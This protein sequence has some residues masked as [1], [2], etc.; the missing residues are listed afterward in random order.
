MPASE[1]ATPSRRFLFPEL[2]A[3]GMRDKYI[4][5]PANAPR[6]STGLL[7]PVAPGPIKT[8]QVNPPDL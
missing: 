7:L 6:H 2:L 4:V 3:A 8:A 5:R 1:L